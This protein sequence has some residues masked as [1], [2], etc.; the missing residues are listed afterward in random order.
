MDS[1]R[2]LAILILIAAV[3]FLAGMQFGE[4]LTIMKM[5]ET[6]KPFVNLDYKTIE[7]AFYRYQNQIGGCFQNRNGTI[8]PNNNTCEILQDSS[9]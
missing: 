5:I 1:R 3:F 9:S 8:I 4:Y 6:A 7:E 2:N